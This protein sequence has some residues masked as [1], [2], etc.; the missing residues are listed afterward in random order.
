MKYTDSCGDVIETE[1]QGG[2]FS[3]RIEGESAYS[4]DGGYSFD[5][6]SFTVELDISLVK[7]LRDELTDYL[8]FHE[9]LD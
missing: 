8:L 3:I 6:D 9:Q 4:T 5:R 1:N 2:V 7:A